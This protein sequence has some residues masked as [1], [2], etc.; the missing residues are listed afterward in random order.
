MDCVV[1]VEVMPIDSLISDHALVTFGLQIARPKAVKRSITF[2]NYK[3]VDQNS[4]SS[5]IETHLT[6]TDILDPSAEGLTMQYNRSLKAL[7]EQ[8][9]P[10]ITKEILVKTESPWYN[11]T[12]ASLRRQ[13]R[14]AERQWRRLGTDSSRSEFV[15]ARRSVVSH[16]QER[17]VEYYQ[18]KWTSC[19]GD[20][21]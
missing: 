10:L 11:N 5:E 6:V 14:K 20:Q 13:R 17:K 8:H 12:I 21:R 4:I 3:N 19:G 1:D 15:A 9:F 2:R 18:N 16:I 7:E